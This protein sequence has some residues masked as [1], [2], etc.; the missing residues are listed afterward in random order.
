MKYKC[1][2]K[3]LRHYRI[4]MVFDTGILV[5]APKPTTKKSF[6]K[7]NR[8]ACF[9]VKINSK[10]ICLVLFKGD[11]NAYNPKRYDMSLRIF[12]YYQ[13]LLLSLHAP[14]VITFYHALLDELTP[15]SQL[16][17][18]FS[19]NPLVVAYSATQNSNI[20]KIRLLK[21]VSQRKI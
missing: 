14:Y 3:T 9:V 17:L 16:T 21:P 19:G 12:V 13:Y 5:W 4:R 10:L 2:D 18:K 11:G 15:T 20:R 8:I 1:G 6:L 7:Q